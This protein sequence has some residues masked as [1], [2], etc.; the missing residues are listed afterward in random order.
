MYPVSMRL[1]QETGATPNLVKK[2]K[3]VGYKKYILPNIWKVKAF[4]SV[5]FLHFLVKHLFETSLFFI[6]QKRHFQS[7]GQEG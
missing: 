1:T 2:S 5:F 3:R 7:G 4:Y 6:P